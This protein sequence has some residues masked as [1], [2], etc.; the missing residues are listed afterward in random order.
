MNY[1]TESQ[2]LGIER[3]QL[4]QALFIEWLMRHYR[5]TVG[6]HVMAMTDTV[7][8]EVVNSIRRDGLPGWNHSCLSAGPVHVSHLSKKMSD[9]QVARVLT[10]YEGILVMDGHEKINRPVC[11][12]QAGVRELHPRS[13]LRT[14]AQ[15]TGVGV[16]KTTS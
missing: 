10:N 15:C 12:F 13:G 9:S 4:R 8:Q 14:S 1:Q 11:Q 5:E 7:V 16:R 2:I 3:R 6:S